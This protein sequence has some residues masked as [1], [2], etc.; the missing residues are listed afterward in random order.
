MSQGHLGVQMETGRILSLAVSWFLCPN[1]SAWEPLGPG[2]GGLTCDL[3]CASNLGEQ[4][5]CCR[6]WV[7]RAMAQGLLQVQTYITRIL[8]KAASIGSCVL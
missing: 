5:S 2:S 3:R 7:W 6:I 4:I 8:S 1:G